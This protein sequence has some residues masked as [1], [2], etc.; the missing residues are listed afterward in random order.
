[1]FG[2][3]RPLAWMLCTALACALAGPVGA[4]GG[5]RTETL[6][7]SHPD[8]SGVEGFRVYYGASSGNYSE[9]FDVGLPPTDGSGNFVY[10]LQVPQ[11]QAV[12]VAVTAY[13]DLESEF[14]NERLRPP[15]D[16]EPQ[17]VPLGQP[18]RPVPVLN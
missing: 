2:T 16:P 10:D 11:D 14:S 9:A 18:G 5:T 3:K 4:Q 8:P 13:A 7:W 15:P 17:P 6:R 12:Y 1:M